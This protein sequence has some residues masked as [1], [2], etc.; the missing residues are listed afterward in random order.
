MPTKPVPLVVYPDSCSYR[1]A[2][3]EALA[4][5]GRTWRIAC[6]SPSAQGS[7]VAVAAGLEAVPMTWSACLSADR[8]QRDVDRASGS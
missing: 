8:G 7:Q 5:A 1:A 6:Q 4:R 3:I 2:A